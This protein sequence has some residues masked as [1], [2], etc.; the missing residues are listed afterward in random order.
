MAGHPS[1]PV[2]LVSYTAVD[3]HHRCGVKIGITQRAQRAAKSGPV[4]TALN[5]ERKIRVAAD[6]IVAQNVETPE[7]AQMLA[8]INA[9]RLA[10]QSITQRYS[11]TTPIQNVTIYCNSP[12]VVHRVN[13]Y[14]NDPS[15][16]P[17]KVV[18]TRDQAMI[19]RVI[20]QFEKLARHSHEVS[21]SFG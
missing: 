21:I 13:F 17:R 18:S 11:K 3:Y 19:K 2:S 8:L 12:S 6:Q 4:D 16:V 15:K 9:L 5:R 1:T 7:R 14:I 10:R 20:K